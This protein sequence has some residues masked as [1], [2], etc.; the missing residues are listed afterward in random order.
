MYLRILSNKVELPTSEGE[1]S[2]VTVTEKGII[3]FMLTLE[4]S[5]EAKKLIKAYMERR[6]ECHFRVLPLTLEGWEKMRPNRWGEG[7]SSDQIEQRD[8]RLN[9]C[10]NEIKRLTDMRENEHK[11]D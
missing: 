5:E 3:S 2:N 10:R 9:H 8:M 4:S 11:K 7:Q 6:T 1:I